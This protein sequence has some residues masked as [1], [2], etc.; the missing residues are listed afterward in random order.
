MECTYFLDVLSQWCFIADKALLKL[1]TKHKQKLTLRCRFV[2][3]AFKNALPVTRAEQIEAYKRSTMI[4][5][6]TT[7]PWIEDGIP[8]H[9]WE[10]NATAVAARQLG[11]DQDLVR[12]EIAQAALLRA[13]PMG[14]DGAAITLIAQKFGVSRKKLETQ[15]RSDDVA[16]TM[17]AHEDEFRALDLSVRPTFVMRNAIG[18]HSVLG[19][20]YRFEVLDLC[21]RGLIEDETAYEFFAEHHAGN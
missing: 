20:A 3:I 13:E 5:G 11:L 21:A 14:R 1:R 15:V 4:T 8:A 16:A 10:A 2:P 12:A 6:T 17:Q 19:G 7:V 18:D 9:T